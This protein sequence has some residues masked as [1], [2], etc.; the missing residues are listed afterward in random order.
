[1]AAR[2]DHLLNLVHYEDAAALCVAALT[3]GSPGKVYLAC[4][5]APLTRAEMMAAVE[6]ARPGKFPPPPGAA[7]GSRV[8]FTAA[9]GPLGRRM[10]AAAT[11][12]ALGWEPKYPSFRAF[13]EA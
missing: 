6:A 7:E 2:P 10:D 9:D 4:D 8:R 5:G 12:K 3:R 13:A 1:M 11:R